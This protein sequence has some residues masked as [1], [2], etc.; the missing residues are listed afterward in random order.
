MMAADDRTPVAA[1]RHYPLLSYCERCGYQLYTVTQAQ[2]Q[3][4][5]PV[6]WCRGYLVHIDRGEHFG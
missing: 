3:K 5:C 4:F 6:S 2:A 1:R